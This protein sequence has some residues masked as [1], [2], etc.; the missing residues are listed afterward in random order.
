MCR[1]LGYLGPPL[2]LQDLILKPSHS[3]VVQSYAPKELKVA[4]LN[5]DG[6]GLGWYHPSRTTDPFTYRSILPAWN[7]VNLAPLCRYIESGCV[8]AYV[9]SA[10]PGQGLDVSNCQPFQSGQRLF[11][12]NGYIRDFRHTLY[13]PMG[14]AMGD[15]AYRQVRGSTDSEHIWGLV[16]SALDQHPDL[17]LEMALERVL[18]TLVTLAR[19][20]QTAVAANILISEGHRLVGCRFASDG[21]APSLYWLRQHGTLGTGTLIASEPLFDGPWLACPD[22]ALFTVEPNCD[23]KFRSL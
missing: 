18:T 19:H 13:R 9:R 8:L 22:A 5:A 3:L 17:P 15:R 14:A 12:H 4:L 10:T 11:V 21:A 20:H 23:P 6:F 1:L 2:P 16:L 7:D